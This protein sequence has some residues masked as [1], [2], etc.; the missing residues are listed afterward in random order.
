M[1]HYRNKLLSTEVS[2]LK[3]IYELQQSIESLGYSIAAGCELEFFLRNPDN[4]E[5]QDVNL[6]KKISSY[7]REEVDFDFDN[8]KQINFRNAPYVQKIYKELKAKD[9]YE[10]TFGKLDSANNQNWIN[11]KKSSPYTIALVSSLSKRVLELESE[12]LTGY[13][14][15]FK[16]TSPETRSHT[17]SIQTSISLWQ[18]NKNLLSS[19][20]NNELLQNLVE[21]L[22]ESQNLLFPLIIKSQDS[23]NR[24]SSG[25]SSP[26]EITALQRYISR[27]NSVAFREK[28][29]RIENRIS[30]SD[31]SPSVSMLISLVGIHLGLDNFLNGVKIEKNRIYELPKSSDEIKTLT[32]LLNKSELA[33]RVLGKDF[34]KDIL[35][36]NKIS[37]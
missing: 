5:I 12:S 36:E 15:L 11:V 20:D 29:G 27:S 37:I 10:I 8:S 26:K 28:E 18:D 17:S 22:V 35:K 23:I 19:K 1:K 2:C 9:E 31:I 16:P 4:S 30:G 13:V 32:S 7:L 34:I 33:Q 24:F 21:G 3:K 14:A 6:Q 25:L